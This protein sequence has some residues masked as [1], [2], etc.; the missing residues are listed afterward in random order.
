M[1]SRRSLI[2]MLPAAS[3]AGAVLLSE[4]AS[5]A[6]SGIHPDTGGAGGNVIAADS[7]SDLRSI[8]IPVR[9]TT[10]VVSG[11][12][13]QGDNGGGHFWWNSG[14]TATDDG[15]TVINPTGNSGSGRW[16]RIIEGRVRA[17]MFGAVGTTDDSSALNAA[18][19]YAKANKINEVEL[20]PYHPVQSTVNLL[21]GV[22]L[23]GKGSPGYLGASTSYGVSNSAGPGVCSRI[24]ATATIAS[25]AVVTLQPDGANSDGFALVNVSIDANGT[26]NYGV[27]LSGASV[28]PA[29][30]FPRVFRADGLFVQG[31]YL[32]GICL[33]DTLV[34][35]FH[36]VTVSACRGWG[37]NCTYGTSDSLFIDT[38]IHTC[39]LIG[40]GGGG[41]QIG[42]GDGFLNF[43]GGKIEDNYGPGVYVYTSTSSNRVYLNNLFIVSNS[44]QGVTM[45]GGNVSING[46]FIGGNSSYPAIQCAAGALNCKDSE[47]GGGTY[48]LSATN[49]G[50][51]RAFNLVMSGSTI[52]PYNNGSTQT[53]QTYNVVLV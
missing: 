34:T 37:L 29:Q 45:N 14:S 52:S 21:A 3:V 9:S 19:A 41:I 48:N 11:Y 33:T 38:Y 44:Y 1:P 5:A 46:G 2:S 32:D 39:G 15:A 12:A 23:I 6:L 17:A 8:N 16:I 40:S 50:L 18:I 28:S 53:I 26:T 25:G 4:T 35:R 27:L 31:A 51:I 36:N 47:I 42:D 13:T 22:A 30:T 10:A 24:R 20:S 7:I 43:I 49:T